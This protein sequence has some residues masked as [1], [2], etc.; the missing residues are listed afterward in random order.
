MVQFRFLA[1]RS[2]RARA[3]GVIVWLSASRNPDHP[4]KGDA[5]RRRGH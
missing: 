2:R 5:D 4:E 3:V 1:K